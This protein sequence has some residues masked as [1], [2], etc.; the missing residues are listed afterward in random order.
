MSLYFRAGGIRSDGDAGCASCVATYFLR[1]AFCLR[2]KLRVGL[3]HVPVSPDTPFRPVEAFFE[4]GYPGDTVPGQPVLVRY[5]A[6]RRTESVGIGM[7]PVFNELFLFLGISK[8]PTDIFPFSGFRVL[9]YLLTSFDPYHAAVDFLPS[10]GRLCLPG[11]FMV[12]LD[13]RTA[14]LRW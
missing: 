7:I 12:N 3:D 8:R 2:D 13:G 1:R 10:G 5:R 9:P 6:I 4:N 11:R 14:C